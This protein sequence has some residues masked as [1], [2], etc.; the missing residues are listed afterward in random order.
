MRYYDHVHN[1]QSINMWYPE[2]KGY[3]VMN[4]RCLSLF[5]RVPGGYADWLLKDVFMNM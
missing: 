1:S 3:S 4:K 2:W 5:E